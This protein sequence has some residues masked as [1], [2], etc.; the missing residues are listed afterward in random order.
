MRAVLDTNTLISAFVNDKRL[1][2][3]AV[4]LWFNRK[5]DLVTSEWQIEELRDVSRRDRIKPLVTPHAVGRFVNLLRAKG[6]VVADLPEVA[7]SS[8]PKDNPILA[9]EIA[10]QVQYIV[11]GDKGHMLDLERVQGIPIVS[12]RD[13]VNLFTR[14]NE[15]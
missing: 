1:P 7:F 14:L 10:G 12:V 6:I 15:R 13:F 11:S 4:D 9:T 5:Y 2:Y 8:D 3:K